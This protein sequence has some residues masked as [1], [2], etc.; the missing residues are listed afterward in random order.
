MNRLHKRVL[1]SVPTTRSVDEVESYGEYVGSLLGADLD[2][3]LGETT[4]GALV[5]KAAGDYEMVIYGP[6][7]PWTDEFLR[8]EGEN[9]RTL[10]R[11]SV[12][13][14]LAHYP[15]QPLRRLLLIVQGAASDQ[16]AAD[17]AL[18]LASSSG[19]AVTALAVVPPVSVVHA[20]SRPEGGVAELLST[21]TVLGRRMRHIAQRLVDKDI[22]CTLRL[23]HGPIMGEIRREALKRMYDLVVVSVA[24]QGGPRCWG[25]G[26]SPV[27]LLRLLDRPMLIA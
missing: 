14:L 23:R 7:R 16:N 6:S 27:S 26:Q 12:P 19:A 3:C 8:S 1:V 11:V 5:E 22:E 15:R 25:V 9:C 10:D 24:L 21:D 18:R 4:L 2:Y 17:W 13:V 20:R